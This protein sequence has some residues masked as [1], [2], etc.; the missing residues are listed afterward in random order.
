MLLEI[1]L[2]GII[3]CM[4]VMYVSLLYVSTSSS[5][6]DGLQRIGALG[7]EGVGGGKVL[8]DTRAGGEGRVGRVSFTVDVVNAV[9][10]P[11]IQ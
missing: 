7:V 2:L 11:G 10:G 5:L 1:A 6:R 3:N 4:D 8:W 9:G